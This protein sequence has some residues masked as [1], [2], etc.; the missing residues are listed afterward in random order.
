MR[1]GVSTEYDPK[2]G[3]SISTLAYEYPADFNVPEHSHGSDQLI[4]ATRGLMQVSAGQSY[5]LIPPQ[6]AVWIS[7]ETSHRIRMSGAVS[8]R[9]LYLRRRLAPRSAGVCTVLHVAPLLRELVLEAVRI[10]HLRTKN[11]L[12][13]ALRNLIVAQLRAASAVPTYVTL[14]KDPRALQVARACIADQATSRSLGALCEE[15]SATVRTIQ[16]AFRRDVGVSFEVWRR[17]VRLTK[18]IELL[19]AGSSV[20]E[21]A[22]EV[23]YRQ[24]SAFVEMFRQTLGTTPKTWAS[25][26]TKDHLGRYGRAGS[27]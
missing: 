21:V 17:Q 6:F 4:Y 5:W 19:V 9:T 18:A 27:F 7:A 23:G 16:R 22:F 15:A 8:M 24:P 26:L 3:V 11:P 14:P 10:G 20:K 2:P 13:C 12:H 25:T 1:H